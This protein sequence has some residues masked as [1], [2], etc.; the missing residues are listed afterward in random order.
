M[1]A[2]VVVAPGLFY[3]NCSSG[4]LEAGKA[5]VDGL[6]WHLWG[7]PFGENLPV[8]QIGMVVGL[9]DSHVDA[10][11]LLPLSGIWLRSRLSPA[12]LPE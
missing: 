7:C 1:G 8:S 10:L 12:N 11:G 3:I 5:I 2:E 4:P 6:N 9:M